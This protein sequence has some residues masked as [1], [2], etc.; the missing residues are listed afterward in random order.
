[1]SKEEPTHLMMM[2]VTSRDLIQLC[3]LVLTIWFA[4]R[5]IDYLTHV[6]MTAGLTAVD[7]NA[8]TYYVKNMANSKE[9]AA[10][11]DDTKKKLFRVLDYLDTEGKSEIPAEL[12][13][14][15]ARMIH[16]HCHRIH[17]NELDADIH[18]TVA[19]NRN[20]GSEIHVCLRQCPDCFQLTEADRVFIVAL[21][22]LAHSATKN[23]D[24]LI[25]GGTVHSDEFKVY[26]KF[27]LETAKKT[28]LV[29]P[30]AQFGKNYCGISIPSV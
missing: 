7:Y 28:G 11:L 14:G 8:T 18:K 10:L 21:H 15:V 25:N 20:K 19:M 26:E 3:V 2:D 16:K 6:R 13:E 17:I 12:A 29:N 22:E 30:S 5:F 1:M 27:L 4:L 23:F 24:P 9:A